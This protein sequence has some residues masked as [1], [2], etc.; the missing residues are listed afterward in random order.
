MKFS[1]AMTLLAT[2][3][4]ASTA[5]ATGPEPF[6]PNMH[7]FLGGPGY[8]VY[9]VNEIDSIDD[10]PVLWALYQ[11]AEECTGVTRSYDPVRVFSASRIAVKDEGGWASHYVGLWGIGTGWIY[12]RRGRSA[13]QTA[14]TI[15][16]EFAHY[17]MQLG[18]DEIN[19]IIAACADYMGRRD[20]GWEVGD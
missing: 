2:V 14:G 13:E 19:D 18:H 5:C 11:M 7:P 8:R 12:I 4:L 17:I 20:I 15:V 6:P 9:D 1:K 10:A 16:H 3:L